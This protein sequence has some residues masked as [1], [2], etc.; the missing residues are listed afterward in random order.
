MT[1]ARQPPVAMVDAPDS[2][3]HPRSD[4]PTQQVRM[5]SQHDPYQRRW[6]KLSFILTELHYRDRRPNRV[7]RAFGIPLGHRFTKGILESLLY[8]A[9]QVCPKLFL[10]P[11]FVK[12][13][14][15]RIDKVAQ[16]LA[17]HRLVFDDDALVDKIITCFEQHPLLLTI[18]EERD[19]FDVRSAVAFRDEVPAAPFSVLLRFEREV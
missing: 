18:D 11:M 2:Q 16:G 17:C 8:R 13:Q 19:R 12:F 9:E 3:G 10:S 4:Q 15:D 1:S 6:C 5:I 14:V 7:M